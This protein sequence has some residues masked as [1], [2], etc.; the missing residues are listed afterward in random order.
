MNLFDE[1]TKIVR[2]LELHQ[3]RYA[4]IGAVAVAFYVEPRFTRDIDLLVDADDYE[5]IRK[6]L[7]DKR[8]FESAS[9]WT[10]QKIA[11]TLHRFLKSDEEEEMIIDLL[12]A[13]SGESKKIIQN[14][15]KAEAAEG[16][17]RIAERNDLIWLKRIRDSKQ[18]Q[19]DIERLIS[20]P[21]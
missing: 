2:E 4:L 8:Y 5:K 20:D 15:V 21:D 9:P 13:E 17:V 6:V 10:F 16:T 19:A 18:D 11:I 3:I 7:E 1:F 12:L 14:A